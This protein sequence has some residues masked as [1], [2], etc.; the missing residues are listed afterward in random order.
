[1]LRI[2]LLRC[3]RSVQPE[4][5]FPNFGEHRAPLAP[6]NPVYRQVELVLPALDGSHTT[7][8]VLCDFL[9]GIQDVRGDT[10]ILARNSTSRIRD[11]PDLFLPLHEYSGELKE[12]ETYLFRI[13]NLSR[14]C[15][16]S[17]NTAPLPETECAVMFFSLFER[18]LAAE[19]FVKN[20]QWA[21]M[22][23]ETLAHCFCPLP[24]LLTNF[25]PLIP[26]GVAGFLT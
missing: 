1:M 26:S 10:H 13:L 22:C 3:G 17:T 16:V 4:S 23:G 25:N 2:F 7:T 12:P 5:Q 20:L 21:G 15:H 8:E 11:D 6:A 24:A 19:I 18:N 9:P 14:I